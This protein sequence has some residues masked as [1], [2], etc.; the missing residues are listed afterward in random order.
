MK[1]MVVRAAKSLSL[2]E[3]PVPRPGR[4]EVRIAVRACG[5]CHSDHLVTDAMWPGLALPRVPGHEIAGVIDAVGE[6][7]VR[8]REGDRVGL[9]W[10][11]GHDGTC[12]AC[13]AGRFINCRA[14][15]I[16]P[17][18]CELD[19]P[20]PILNRSNTLKAMAHSKGSALQD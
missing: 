18:V 4:G 12:D 11:G 1:A 5:V 20:M 15:R 13:L 17:T 16:G 9:G 3:R 19:G 10:H 8:F 7:S 14:A 6:G 2:E